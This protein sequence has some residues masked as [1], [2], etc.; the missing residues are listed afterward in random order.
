MLYVFQFTF[1]T[2]LIIN[3]HH[4][5]TTACLTE[6]ARVGVMVINLS[7]WCLNLSVN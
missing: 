6:E 3:R 2:D 7:F 4:M 5:Q 1:C